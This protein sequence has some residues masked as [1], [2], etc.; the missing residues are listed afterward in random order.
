MK[1]SKFATMSC[2][3]KSAR[4]AEYNLVFFPGSAPSGQIFKPVLILENVPGCPDGLKA[5]GLV[6]R[7]NACLAIER[8]LTAKNTKPY[9]STPTVVG[10]P[11][12]A[13]LHHHKE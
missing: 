10:V 2:K 3:P 7:L 9:P 5:K 4:F 1:K 8:M 13:I 11:W 6:K 12:D